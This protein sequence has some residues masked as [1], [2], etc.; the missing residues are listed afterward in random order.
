MKIT[1]D[2]IKVN[3]NWG[4]EFAPISDDAKCV[5]LLFCENNIW[6][7]DGLY[8]MHLEKDESFVVVWG[9]LQLDI[10]GRVYKLKPGDRAIRVKPLT[11][12][13][14]RSDFCQFLEGST[15]DSPEDTVRGTLE[16]LRNWSGLNRKTTH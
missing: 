5:K 10:E 13:R 8:H 3:K 6:S 1:N 4:W 7:S 14:F 12:H 2:W 9:V 11:P 16:D 15:P